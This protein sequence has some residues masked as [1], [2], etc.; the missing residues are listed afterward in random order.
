MNNNNWVRSLIIT[1][2]TVTSLVLGMRHLGILEKW[3]LATFDQSIRLRPPEKPDPRI[4][5]VKITE[6]DIQIIK[7]WP[8]PDEV[9]AKA[10]TKLQQYKPSVIGLDIYRDLPV[11]PGNEAFQQLLINSDRLIAICKIKEDNNPGIPQPPN[12]NPDQVGFSDI[13]LDSDQ[14]VRRSLLFVD[15]SDH[16]PCPNSLSFSFQLAQFYLENKNINPE[17]I[18][19]KYLKFG[20]KLFLPIGQENILG[21]FKAGG[22][23]RL[24][25]L[26]GYQILINYRSGKIAEE[27][28]LNDVLNDKIKPELIQDKIV[29]IGADAEDSAK[30]FF[31]TPYYESE[32]YQ[33]KMPGV[34]IH[35]HGVSQIISSVLDNRPLLW[36]A[37]QYVDVLW[38][39]SWSIIGGIIVCVIGDLRLVILGEGM[40]ISGLLILSL[41]VFLQAGWLPL[42]PSILAL[43]S[44][45]LILI[46]NKVYQQNIEYKNIVRKS[47]EA[48]QSIALLESLLNEQALNNDLEENL[49]ISLIPEAT[50]IPQNTHQNNP[51]STLL[52]GRY[53]LKKVLGSG[54]FAIT[55]V[56][57][58]IQR[59]GN[60]E[61][62][63][64][65]LRP[66]RKDA[67]FLEV[68]RRL[69]ATEAEILE[70]LGQHSQIP[71]LLAYFEESSQFYLVEEFIMG[72]SLIEEMPLEKP[73]AEQK[74]IE[75][76]KSVLQIL[77]FIHHH[78]VIHRDIKPGN[79]MR[80]DS[81]NKL[82]LIDFG[83][84]KLMQPKNP[85]IKE[86][87]LTVAIGT[88]GYAPP[89][90]YAGK[91][92][93]NSDIYALGMVAI[94]A[95]TGIEPHD[96]EK[97]D[98]G[99]V[100]WRNFA[101]VTPEFADILDLMVKYHFLDR[102][103]TATS[104]LQ[105]IV[106][107]EF[108][109]RNK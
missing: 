35:A 75:I 107:L 106:M 3:E 81:D 5:I 22:Y 39:L 36:Y 57:E 83:A 109:L 8:L 44:T 1:T 102:Y 76:V 26:H 85:M 71:Q 65:Q 9:L 79:I 51:F 32:Q 64:K 55:Y 6:E 34:I 17:L 62:V 16:K 31:R 98:T 18:Q 68:A 82:V 92:I 72:H 73:L 20:N 46:G 53:Q 60:P 42:I 59:P 67:K 66:A 24:T 100:I 54:G 58:D 25:G 47:E 19:D 28:T 93:F 96:L 49:P 91:P 104:A 90:Q 43:I 94:Q 105:E 27:V 56:A 15:P 84:V 70:Q 103:Q 108:K 86:K 89:E 12:I 95:L 2:I 30:D 4:L 52:T 69:F 45:S 101:N 88:R 40:A 41:V 11:K 78:H 21:T 14:I 61:C 10:I 37:P 50:N 29:I 87:N 13:V 48:A 7:K 38:I 97:D 99:N 63:V 23:Q 33:Q 80:R 74:V 77:Q